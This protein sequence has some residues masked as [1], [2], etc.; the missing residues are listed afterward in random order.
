M[1]G[2]MGDFL[3]HIAPVLWCHQV[4]MQGFQLAVA[5]QRSGGYDNRHPRA[6]QQSLEGFGARA[7]AAHYNCF[8]AIT[9]FAPAALAV[10]ALTTVGTTHVYLAVAFV[11]CRIVYLFCYWYDID[12]LRSIMFVAGLGISVAL[13]ATLL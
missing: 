7:N 6:Q 12:K 3:L 9:Y 4:A 11:I 1:N 8:E 2:A 5:M 10:L 13:F